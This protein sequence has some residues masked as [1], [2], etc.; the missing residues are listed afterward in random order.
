MTFFAA[1][2]EPLQLLSLPNPW[3][4]AAGGLCWVRE[5]VGR[6]GA[7]LSWRAPSS[8][9]QTLREVRRGQG[10]PCEA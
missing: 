3:N 2:E 6:F 1:V 10:G 5:E 4:L 9:W 8:P 7:G